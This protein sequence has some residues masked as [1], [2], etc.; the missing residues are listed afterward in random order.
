MLII[1]VFITWIGIDSKFGGEFKALNECHA[2]MNCSFRRKFTAATFA[3][4]VLQLKSYCLVN[5]S[6]RNFLEFTKFKCF[7][8]ESFDDD[9]VTLHTRTSAI[10]CTM[11]MNHYKLWANPVW[12]CSV[13]V[14]WNDANWIDQRNFQLNFLN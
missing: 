6:Q 10:E 2:V 3:F 14:H 11:S 8:V 1:N 5:K 12:N 13:S 4:F 7:C 9:S